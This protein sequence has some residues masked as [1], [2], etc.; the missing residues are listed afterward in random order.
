MPK[1]SKIQKIQMAKKTKYREKIRKINI[2]GLS[3][4]LIK[5]CILKIQ[6]QRGLYFTVFFQIQRANICI[7]MHRLKSVERVCVCVLLLSMLLCHFDNLLTKLSPLCCFSRWRLTVTG[8]HT[9][10]ALVGLRTIVYPLLQSFLIHLLLCFLTLLD[11]CEP[12]YIS[13]YYVAEPYNA[14]TS[15]IFTLFG[16]LGLFYCNPTNEWRF[17]LLTSVAVVIGLGSTALHATL[18]WFFQSMD[19]VPMLWFNSVCC[20][21]IYNNYTRSDA[22]KGHHFDASACVFFLATA[23][24]TFIYYFLQSLYV[25][26]IVTYSISNT[27][28]VFWVYAY[29]FGKDCHKHKHEKTL[30]LL[31]KLVFVSFFAIGFVCW[32]VD[33]NLCHHLLPFYQYTNGMTLHVVWHLGAG[34]GGYLMTLILVIIRAN[35]LDVPVELTWHWFIVPIVSRVKGGNKNE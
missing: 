24:G 12:D 16:L 34:Y 15:L 5:N 1:Q 23:M 21:C 4:V 30:K 13:Q 28:I 17:S 3:L 6:V 8:I 20:Y 22:R 31:G 32:L 26:F 10:L 25:V 33:M 29:L 7:G 9:P 14:V 18:H 35:A 11:F 19:E 27:I 2:I